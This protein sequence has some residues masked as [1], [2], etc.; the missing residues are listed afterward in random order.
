MPSTKQLL[1][2]GN[3]FDINCGL[4]S[5]Y[6]HFFRKKILDTTTES[7][8]VCKMQAGVTGFW[9]ELLFGYY[10]VYKNT[11]YNWA[12]VETIIK[13]TLWTICFGN[14]R[15]ESNIIDGIWNEAIKCLWYK[16]DPESWAKDIKSSIDNY[17]F[18]YCY[19]FYL[20]RSTNAALDSNPKYLQLLLNHLLQEL[21][22]FERR[23][24]KYLRDNLVNPQNAQIDSKYIV[25]AVNLLAKLTGFT[26]KRF[27]SFQSI[28]TI[29]QKPFEEK[30][31]GTSALCARVLSEQFSNLK[32]THILSFNYTSLFDLLEVESP[33]SYS[34]VHGKL[35][36]YSCVTNCN[37]TSIIFGIDDNLIQL[38]NP[39]TEL[40]IFSKTY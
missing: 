37:I 7:F 15:L 40:R 25:N 4:K 36:N 19:T 23:F 9:E 32:N 31:S 3:G 29:E 28:F 21:Y 5:R 12:D 38:E 8:G 33:C 35:C 17:L 39:C 27:N 30:K 24:C 26:E 22:S 34:N 10:T 14:K 16:Q 18:M 6:E 1:I 20:Q 11:D 13:D 2:L